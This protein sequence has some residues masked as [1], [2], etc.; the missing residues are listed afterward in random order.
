MKI[1][2][3]NYKMKSVFPILLKKIAYPAFCDSVSVSMYFLH[4]CLLY[5]IGWLILSFR[6]IP[7]VMGLLEEI[8]SL[9]S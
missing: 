4:N 2:A 5:F 8:T 9:S 7:M 6:F 1:C 3:Y